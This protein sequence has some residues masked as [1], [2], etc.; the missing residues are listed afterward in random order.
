MGASEDF[1]AAAAGPR[2]TQPRSLG[3]G[4]SSGETAALLGLRLVLGGHSRA[5]W[6]AAGP[7]G[8]QPRSLG[9]GCAALCSSCRCGLIS[10]F[11]CMVTDENHFPRRGFGRRTS[12]DCWSAAVHSIIAVTSGQR[13]EH[14]RRERRG[15]K[16][17]HG[18]GPHRTISPARWEIRRSAERFRSCFSWRAWCHLIFSGFTGVG[19]RGRHRGLRRR[20]RGGSLRRGAGWR[21]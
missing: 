18:V 3:C 8:R 4:W 9:C 13:V 1:R 15:N 10:V 16:G 20:G 21:G 2:R 7:R 14:Q 12:R 17:P 19:G 5:P 11:H 6:V